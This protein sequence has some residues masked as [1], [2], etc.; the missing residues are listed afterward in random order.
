LEV[1]T[2]IQQKIKKPTQNQKYFLFLMIM[3]QNVKLNALKDAYER[4]LSTGVV[5]N[6]S[7]FSELLDINRTT[8]SSAMNG[9]PKAL[10]DSLVA[11]AVRVA[12][13]LDQRI[14]TNETVPIFPFSV[15]AGVSLNDISDGMT[16]MEL[17]RITSPVRGAE[18]AIEVTGDSMAPGY[19]A[20]ARVLLKRVPADTYI[21]WGEVFVVEGV[22]GPVLK[23]I[24]PT[25]DPTVW[26]LRS[27][28]PAYPPFKIRTDQVRSV[29][30]VLLRMIQ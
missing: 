8:L 4:C 28:N 13:E 19:P 21:T 27:D 7:E 25:E 11:K 29:W 10:T 1:C 20:G 15:R 17:E 18:L 26:E 30:R 14:S 5:R 6:Q 22:N 3:E 24:L 23:R 16:E 9:S 12:N 2:K